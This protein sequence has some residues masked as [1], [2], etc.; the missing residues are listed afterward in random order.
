MDEVLRDLSFLDLGNKSPA[1]LASILS[2]E[3]MAALEQ[4]GSSR[5]LRD[6]T[7]DS[8]TS[9][10]KRF[11]NKESLVRAHKQVINHA[12][13]AAKVSLADST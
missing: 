5:T 11:E 13:E 4:M 10:I 12:E 6:Q 2:P 3:K 7:P 1:Q 9:Q 8:P